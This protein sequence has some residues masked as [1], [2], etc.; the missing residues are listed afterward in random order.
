MIPMSCGRYTRRFTKRGHRFTGALCAAAL[1]LSLSAC[2]K[3]HATPDWPDPAVNPP[4]G[5]L[6]GRPSAASP[7]P[8]RSHGAAPTKLPATATG[9]PETATTGLRFIEYNVEN[10]LTMDRYV[11][12]KNLKHSPKPDSEKLAV[13]QILSRQNPDVIGLCEIGE[14][15]DLAEIQQSLKSTGVDLPYAH[16]AGGS[17]P[18]RRLGLLSRFPLTLPSQPA[19]TEYQMRGQTFAINRGIL[20]AS[21]NARGKSYRLLG[22][23]LKSKREIEGADQE[24]MRIH[25]ASLLRRQVDAILSAQ[26][27]A[28]LIVYGDFNDTRPSKAFK[29]VTGNY[30]DPGYLTAI[31]FRDARGESWTHY[32][33]L[34][35]IYSRF[36]FVAVTRA[37]KPDVDFRA[38]RLIDDPTWNDAS[39]HRP[40]LAI[41]R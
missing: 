28:R 22:V 24:E 23:H 40:L 26:P 38:S 35:D 7:K 37:L 30:N 25:E 27:D 31:P 6:H 4:A 39:D 10:W 21:I 15:A 13:I 36:D 9:T 29:T 20:D 19:A 41:F 11:N 2:G 32:W 14:A 33:S 3:K 12:Q 34:H 18:V 16:S 17:D 1:A 5:E 8:A